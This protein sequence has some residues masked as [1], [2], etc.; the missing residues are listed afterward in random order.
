VS[1]RAIDL[2]RAL[3]DDPRIFPAL[4][5]RWS[6]L[7][8]AGKVREL[9]KLAGEFM[10]LAEQK[11]TRTDRMVGHRLLGTALRD[12][13]TPRAC[14]ELEMASKL[15]DRQS[16][17]ATALV[18]GTDVQVTSLCNLVIGYWM[19]GRVTLAAE[20]ARSAL[21]L[22]T[23]LQHAFTLCYAFAH[24]CMLHALERNVA[25]VQSL[26][27][28]ML[29]EATRRE[30]PFW[31]SFSRTF[32][33][34]CELESGRV[35]EGIKMLEG[36]RDFLRSARVA[37]W[38]PMYLCWLAE[39]H[40]DTGNE[41]EAKACLDEARA[42][43]GGDANFWYEI[44]CLRI[45]ARLTGDGARAEELFG[46]SLE[47]AHQR[48]QAG[49]ALRAAHG[50][51]QYLAQKGEGVRARALLQEALLPF[52]EQPD[53]GDRREAKDLLRSLE[54]RSRD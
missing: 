43:I 24:A 32:L 7:R 8:V 26:A 34:W 25:T 15:Y 35:A 16:D 11:G 13:D 1:T 30:L 44:E 33:G 9:G 5:A 40:A 39:G 23:E 47:L 50:F 20:R 17:R 3:N 49:F 31:I 29:A 10:G 21:V 6:N 52:A 37:F 28:Q 54:A 2:C 42:I 27:E 46:R 12:C 22:A 36:E 41:T 14:E 45:E 38:L 18:Y 51:A 4:Y 19:L 48:G 53:S